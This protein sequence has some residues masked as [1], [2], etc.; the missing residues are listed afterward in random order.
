MPISQSFSN[1]TSYSIPE[2]VAS[3]QIQLW[4]AGGGGE[5]V[6]PFNLASTPG[7]S[8]GST[9]WV[10]ITAFGGQGGGASFGKG[11]LG[12]GGGVDFGGYPGGSGATGAI[13]SFYFGGTG[14]GSRGNGGNGTPGFFVYQSS[15]FHVFDNNTN[16]FIF[17]VTS[18]DISIDYLNPSAPDAL[19]GIAPSNGKYYRV[20]FNQPYVDSNYSLEIPF[21][22][23][24]SAG[25]QTEFPPYSVNAIRN[26]SA[27]GFDI[28][29]QNGKGAN[30]Y[31]RRFDI[32]TTG[33]KSG[34]QGRG[35]G[36][37]G[38][39][40]ITVSRD[41]LIS[42]GYT[43]GAAYTL[44]VGSG[45]GGG[46]SDTTGGAGGFAS[47]VM[48]I[49]PRVTLSTSKTFLIIGQCAELTWSTTG[50]ASQVT[51]LSGNVS[52]RNLT[53]NTTVCPTQT[54]TYTVIAS[55][56]GG[57]SPPATV[58]ITVA[59][60]PTASISSPETINYGENAIL[61]Y[62]TEYA[63]VSV[64]ITPF[65]TF[66]DLSTG[67]FFTS[68]GATI[69]LPAAANASAGLPGTVASNSAYPFPVAY[70]ER[71]PYSIQFLIT[72]A[73][74]GG[75]ATATST[76]TVIIDESPDNI[77]IP[78][79]DGRFK[80]ENPVF[81]PQTEVLSEFILV[82][83]VDVPVEIKSSSPIQVNI[84]HSGNWQDLRSI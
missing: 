79:T 18:N 23:Q 51:W 13:G 46:G 43:P 54:T 12:N 8:G 53:S 2:D 44:T 41:Q 66:R 62:I 63:N 5:Y 72:A 14:V 48:F 17:T 56:S 37:G 40:N 71:G 35:G 80:S 57:T 7:A 27:S 82:D 21:V 34:A 76:T 65:Y 68:Q 20:T 19:F 52:N 77:L 28:W 64:T 84:N 26:K 25:G 55:G 1:T 50:D 16:S 83:G 60:P 69:N 45:G 33:L 15:S 74:A 49:Q 9:S 36:A 29:F 70:D 39:V 75:Q 11:S 38:Y 32:T 67:N 81:T 24:Q 47:L 10:G 78:E 42:R 31:I 22:S 58:T 61:S 30:G 73:G 4:G 3:M 59:N 6:N